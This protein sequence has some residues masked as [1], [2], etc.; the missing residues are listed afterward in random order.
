MPGSVIAILDVSAHAARMG[1]GRFE[2]VERL[3]RAGV[4]V[5]RESGLR[6]GLL[7]ADNNGWAFTLPAALVEAEAGENANAPNAIQ[8]STAQILVLRAELPQP[9]P[10]AAAERSLSSAQSAL[11]I[12]LGIEPVRQEVLEHV[13]RELQVAPPQPFDLA[14]QVQVYTALVQFVELEMKGWKLEGRRI[15]LPRSL[16]VLATQDR[17]L[18]QRIRASLNLLDEMQDGQLKTLRSEVEDIRKAFCR[19]VGGLGS[20]VLVQARAMLEKRV[21][22]VRTRLA[23]AKQALIAE[24]EAALKRVVGSLVPELARAVLR[25]PTD[26]FRARFAQN[27]AGAEE[28]VRSE[29]ERVLPRAE[30]IVGAMSLRLTFKDVTYDV[31][32]DQT[33]KDKVLMSFSRSALPDALLTEYDAV[34]ERLNATAPASNE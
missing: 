19:P 17:D 12:S 33:F 2:Y 1:Y 23:N 10:R 26:T 11:S 22:D 29:L 14:R 3:V 31:L 24:I 25:G 27:E 7:V 16:P 20:L 18:K 21:A 28:Y 15:E 4:D 8:L 5:R 32:K 30:E 6:L 34:R 13:E 9:R